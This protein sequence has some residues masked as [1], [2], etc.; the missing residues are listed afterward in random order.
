MFQLKIEG[1]NNAIPEG[2]RQFFQSCEES[3]VAEHEYDAADMEA[4]LDELGTLLVQT[5]S[6]VL[7]LRD[8]FADLACD[9]IRDEI[10]EDMEDEAEHEVLIL[11]PSGG[12]EVIEAQ[13]CKERFGWFDKVSVFEPVPDCNNLFI[14]CD[15]KNMISVGDKKYIIGPC[16]VIYMEDEPEQEGTMTFEDVLTAM[17]A[18]SGRYG[19]LVDAVTGERKKVICIS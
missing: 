13:E 12:A 11:T 5:T 8:A 1:G 16:V 10:E 15:P 6:C 2:F 18:L 14:T 3:S 4:L 17:T 7:K 19:F 9:A